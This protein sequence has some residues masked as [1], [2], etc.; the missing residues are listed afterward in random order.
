MNQTPETVLILGGVPHS[1]I[2]FRGP[3]LLAINDLGYAVHA[4]APGLLQ[5]DNVQD[6]LSAEGIHCHNVLLSRVGLS[7]VGDLIALRELFRLMRKVRPEHFLAYTIKPVIWGLISAWIAGVPNRVALITGLGY[8]FTGDARGKRALIQRVARSLYRFSLRRATLI[9]FQNPDDQADFERLGLL[10]KAVPVVI[11]NGSG[12]DVQAFPPAPFP[13]TPLRFLLIARLL[14]DKGIREYVSAAA[15]V[16]AV[17]PEVEFHLV[18]G[19]DP[20][21]DGIAEN[22]VRSWH[23]AGGIFWHGKLSDVRPTIAESHVYVLPSYYREGTPRTVLEAMAM[24]R[25]V[26]T[27]D[28]PGCRETVIDGDNG[29]LVPVKSVE[30]LAAAM[31]RFIETPEM[32]PKMGKRSRQIAEEKYDVH[33][34]NAVMLKAMGITL[35]THNDSPSTNR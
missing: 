22:E 25:P 27:T 14:G 33:K 2:N 3:L 24:G 11:V 17:H 23:N 13:A 9:F 5:D 16:R 34:V 12:V 26:I 7:P 6:G 10:P 20:N 32:I 4:A 29:F 19:L 30:A 1:L 21:P 8:A 31:I 18:G 28:A 15:K 35:E